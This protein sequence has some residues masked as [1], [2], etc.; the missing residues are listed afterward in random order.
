MI[1]ESQIKAAIRKATESGKSRFELKGSGE[2]GAGRLALMGRILSARVTTERYAVY[3]R[4]GRRILNKIGSYPTMPL[5][6]ARKKF[7]EEYAPTISA[8]ADPESRTS[9]SPSVSDLCNT[10]RTKVVATTT[11]SGRGACAH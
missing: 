10:G 7:R 3:H 6:E 1:T 9:A 4:S 2:H 11:T 8:G 5:G